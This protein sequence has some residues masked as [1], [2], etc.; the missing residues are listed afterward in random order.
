MPSTLP[1]PSKSAL[2]TLRNLALGTSC[3]VAFSVGLLTADR[4][5]RIHAAREIRDN[6]RKLKSTRQYHSNDDVLSSDILEAPI[7]KY[8]NGL[9]K[10]RKNGKHD[11]KGGSYWE[12]MHLASSA[13]SNSIDASGNGKTFQQWEP[14]N[15]D[16]RTRKQSLPEL[17][18]WKPPET[19]QKWSPLIPL[20]N[21]GIASSNGVGKPTKIAESRAVAT[22][23]KPVGVAQESLL[24][25]NPPIP[26]HQCSYS[27]K[28]H[29]SKIILA[30][31]VLSYN[32]Q[33][34]QS[35][36]KSPLPKPVVPPMKQARAFKDALPVSIHRS[37]AKSKTELESVSRSSHSTSDTSFHKIPTE[38]SQNE[39]RDSLP[40][41]I[42]ARDITRILG[43]GSQPINIAAATRRFFDAFEGE[44]SLGESG[45]HEELLEA[46]V[47]LSLCCSADGKFDR[48]L[49]WVISVVVSCSP[50]DKDIFL[51]F[52]PQAMLKGLLFKPERGGPV[53]DAE[54]PGLIQLIR[55]GMMT[56]VIPRL[57][58]ACS[59]YS[60]YFQS[61]SKSHAGKTPRGSIYLG[62]N[63]CLRAAQSNLIDSAESVF[64]TLSQYTCHDGAAHA[65]TVE[66]LILAT[67]KSGRPSDCIQYFRNFFVKLAPSQEVFESVTGTVGLALL[68]I[69]DSKNKDENF[70]AIL[71]MAEREDLKVS[72]TI[73]LKI[74][75]QHWNTHRN[76]NKSRSLFDRL[77][78]LIHTTNHPQQ[79]YSAIIQNCVESDDEPMAHQYYGRL[80]KLYPRRPMD[81]GIYGHLAHAKA[82]QKDWAGVR[83][84]FRFMKDMSLLV[85]GSGKSHLGEFER[86]YSSSFTPILRRFSESHS[87]GET[88]IFLHEFMEEFSILPLPA[89]SQVMIKQYLQNKEIDSMS[90]WLSYMTS[91]SAKIDTCFFD[92]VL[93][94]CASQWQ[95]SFEEVLQ[96]YQ[97]VSGLGDRS[98]G[99]I[100]KDTY[101][102]L[103]RIAMST[104]GLDSTKA[105]KKLNH[106][107][108]RVGDHFDDT[109]LSPTDGIR[110]AFVNG[111]F[112]KALKLYKY[113]LANGLPLKSSALVL[114]VQAS[115]HLYP[116][117]TDMTTPLIKD[118]KRRGEDVFGASSA[119]IMHEICH[120]GQTTSVIEVAQAVISALE[121]N[122]DRNKTAPTRIVSRIINELSKKRSYADAV[123][124]WTTVSTHEGITPDLVILT[125]LLR[126]FLGLRDST[127]LRW[128]MSQ[129]QGNGYAPD[130]VFK[131][132]L[133]TGRREES[134]LVAKSERKSFFAKHI[135]D[136][137]ETTRVLI[138]DAAREREG[139]KDKIT[140]IMEKA[141]V[142]A[143]T[144]TKGVNNPK[145]AGVS[146]K[147]SH[148]QAKP[149]LNVWMGKQE[150]KFSSKE[151]DAQLDAW[152]ES[153][154]EDFGVV[155][156]PKR[157][158]ATFG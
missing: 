156:T 90:R 139:V 65:S 115:L 106:L 35:P 9:W 62:K 33:N 19:V 100:N 49:E 44:I 76:L 135:D 39:I 101:L 84:D 26:T 158:A 99:F 108:R 113:A 14:Q 150:E 10:R 54:R 41:Q 79:M 125:N 155:L 145:R 144:Q 29:K 52:E 77:E 102:T 7:A 37:E 82:R 43:D 103:R 95:F 131:R 96:M 66:A 38:A 121:L 133:Q 75:R 114:A 25:W 31:S 55:R 148:E 81:V 17:E 127:G 6:A 68:D 83:T 97:S 50:M 48:E 134:K 152:M 109:Y 151:I 34:S 42:I 56:R 154:D 80:R 94:S 32:F 112:P 140:L 58:M 123:D 143:E 46:A 1:V 16:E 61:Q 110:K 132:T 86:A 70:L 104:S 116:N 128:V 129:I 91:T 73:C 141:L 111:N 93:L 107:R 89:I 24:L 149:L 105:L 20:D 47:K 142:D 157:A 5:R 78:P 36:S 3:T 120:N 136:A 51:K 64:Q 153:E 118:A 45:L 4:R 147:I 27:V 60:A 146:R 119:I 137:L 98:H 117:S 30:G 28:D 11:E 23:S 22:L 59:L 53:N 92:S 124:F 63:L 74:F 87:I 15:S 57:E 72:T 122:T 126:A 130:E 2:R 88:E 69:Q 8:E 18:N 71:S 138:A 67:H 12:E 85:P 13:S 21:P 40:Q